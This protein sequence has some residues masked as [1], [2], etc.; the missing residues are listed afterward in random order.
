MFRPLRGKMLLLK[1]KYLLLLYIYI[2]SMEKTYIITYDKEEP[3]SIESLKLMVEVVPIFK[4]LLS[5]VSHH[6]F[7]IAF[8]FVSKG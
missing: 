2:R 3:I 6:Y 5:D 7:C 1:Y 4:F 8:P